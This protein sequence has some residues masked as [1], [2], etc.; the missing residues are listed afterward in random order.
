M[1]TLFI[2]D[3]HFFDVKIINERKCFDSVD[4]MHETLIFNWNTKVKNKDEVWIGGDFAKTDKFCD[5]LLLFESLNGYKNVLIGNHDDENMI[6]SL[7]SVERCK[8]REVVF[9]KKI[10]LDNKEVF[11]NHYP[12]LVWPKRGGGAY[13][14]YGHVHNQKHKITNMPW[15]SCCISA[16]VLNYEPKTFDELC[17]N[18]MSTESKADWVFDN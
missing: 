4:Q 17:C 11:L 15:R 3:L 10:I 1:N 14:L 12:T 18:Y 5:L 6:M 8:I 7:K 9:Q 16:E 13:H 2:A